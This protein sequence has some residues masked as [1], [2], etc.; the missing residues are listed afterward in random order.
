[1][2]ADVVDTD[3][4]D[5]ELVEPVADAEPR[6]VVDAEIVEDDAPARVAA[7]IEA[8]RPAPAPT[9][10]PKAERPGRG[11]LRLLRE[12]P[13]LR[14]RAVAALVLPFILYTVVL[15]VISRLDVY[16]FWIWIPAILAGVLF[17]AQLDVAAKRAAASAAAKE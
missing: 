15:V 8:P 9:P 17:G 6:N 3:V 13:S 10:A 7:A 11:D 2:D 5:P 1:V 16:L 12:N 14:A 4:I